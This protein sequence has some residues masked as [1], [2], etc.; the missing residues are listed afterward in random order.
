MGL[1]EIREKYRPD[2]PDRKIGRRNTACD[3]VFS[4]FANAMAID[5]HGTW[6]TDDYRK[7]IRVL[8]MAHLP[9]H[10]GYEM[11]LRDFCR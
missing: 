11:N 5:G 7:Y 1:N 9:R 10:E 4:L 6:H 2:K 3:I 8:C